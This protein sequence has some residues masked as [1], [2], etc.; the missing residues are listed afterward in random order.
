MHSIVKVTGKHTHYLQDLPWAF[1]FL[2]HA[3]KQGIKPANYFC[4]ADYTG[5]YLKLSA[6]LKMSNKPINTVAD[7]LGIFRVSPAT[8]QA[9]GWAAVRTNSTSRSQRSI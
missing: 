9:L 1:P 8:N 6:G 7:I 5:T 3:I 4:Q 2:D